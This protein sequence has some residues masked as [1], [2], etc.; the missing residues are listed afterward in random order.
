MDDLSKAMQE[1]TAYLERQKEEKLRPEPKKPAAKPAPSRVSAVKAKKK[2]V[3]SNPPLI[4]AYGVAIALAIV[5][6]GISTQWLVPAL[7]AGFG[8]ATT[9]ITK[10]LSGGGTDYSWVVPAGAGGLALIGGVAVVFLVITIV[11]RARGQLYLAVL[12][13]LAVLAGFC[14]DMCKDFYPNDHLVRIGFAGVTC[15]LYA[16]GGLWWRRYG[17]LNKIAGAL[18]ILIAPLVILAHGVSNNL[19]QGLSVALSNVTTQS[20]MALGGLLSILLLAG[21]LAFTLGEEISP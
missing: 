15:G 8:I 20:W 14:V 10:G 18:V 3:Q 16:L 7:G 17:L 13:L 2:E 1:A 4:L 5:A 11:K 9:I 19:N 6:V 21:L 12:P